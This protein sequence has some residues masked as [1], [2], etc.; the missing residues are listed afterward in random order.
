[1][2]DSI[3]IINEK[4]NVAVALKDF[5]AGQKASAGDMEPIRVL[6]P[7]PAAHKIALRDIEP[8]ENIIKYGETVGKST[9][10]IKKGAW[11]HAHNLE[12]GR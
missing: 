3:L 12:G 10:R 11:V 8:G 4:D 9:A 7:V 2:K 5:D 6:E 1:M